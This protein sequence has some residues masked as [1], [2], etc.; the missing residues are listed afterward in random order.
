MTPDE[1][2]AAELADFAVYLAE[3]AKASLVNRN[4][5]VN[6][7]LLK[8]LSVSAAENELKMMFADQGRM[9]DMGA[10][11]G[12]SK[13]KFLGAEDRGSLLRPRKGRKPSKWYSRLAWGATYGTLVNNLQNKYIAEAPAYLTESFRK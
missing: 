9:H 12:Y 11:R 3:Q 7:E 13:G 10:G 1:F 2:I 6:D 5:R 8:S 4:I